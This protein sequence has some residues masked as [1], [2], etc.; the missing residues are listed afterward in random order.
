M[1]LGRVPELLDVA[2]HTAVAQRCKPGSP[3]PHLDHHE[4]LKREG[5]QG[6]R[7]RC[8]I[9]RR[10]E[11]QLDGNGHLHVLLIYE[12]VHDDQ[13]RGEVCMR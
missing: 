9:G 6:A 2:C 1:R 4:P 8:C 11:P 12:G 5:E 7:Q 10:G 3:A 13:L